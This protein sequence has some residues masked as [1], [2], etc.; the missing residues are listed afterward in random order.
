MDTPNGL[1]C[2]SPGIL[3]AAC[4]S[5]SPSTPTPVGGGGTPTVTSIAISGSAAVGVNS[6]TQLTVTAMLSNN[7]SAVVTS[8]ASWT[9][10]STSIATVDGS[11]L[12]R[13]VSEGTVQITG[14]YQ[15]QSAQY[16]MMVSP[17]SYR[18]EVR[19]TSMTALGSCDG[20]LDDTGEFALQVNVK[21]TNRTDFTQYETTGYPGPAHLNLEKGNSRTTAS[22]RTFDMVTREAYT[23]T[24]E[25][26]ATEWDTQIVVFPPS[27]RDVREDDMNNRS[28]TRVHRFTNGQWSELGPRR[29]EI[30]NS[31]CGIRLDYE[32]SVTRQ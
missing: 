21:A 5:N 8:Q 26:R 28:N 17:L 32:I 6:T 29:V 14:T 3:A 19:T 7:T 30:G 27:T 23:V 4:S 16:G 9:S 11:G 20:I 31:S 10:G 2:A 12:V 22:V 24:V 25:L 18:F 15:G 13:G 1:I